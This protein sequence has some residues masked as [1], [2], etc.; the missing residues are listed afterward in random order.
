[1]RLRKLLPK[2]LC[3][4]LLVLYGTACPEAT[5]APPADAETWFPVSIGGKTVRLQ[6]ALTEPERSRGLMHRE[7]LPED[8]GMAFLF[9]SPDRRSFWMRNTGIPLD[10]AYFDEEGV[11]LEIHR[12]YPYDETGVSS[13]SDEV[14]IAVETNQGWFSRHGIRPDAT[15]DLEALSAAVARRG[16]SPSDFHLPGAN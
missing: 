13:R 4:V 1:M 6:L 5:D 15:L 11:L 12:L 9:P 16:F 8:H 10:L 14:L 7:K 3:L 2:I